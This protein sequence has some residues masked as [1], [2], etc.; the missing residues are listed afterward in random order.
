M[1]VYQRAG[2]FNHHP[3]R[4]PAPWIHPGLCQSSWNPGRR[5]RRCKHSGD[6]AAFFLGGFSRGWRE[7]KSNF[8]VM[9]YLN[10]ATFEVKGREKLLLLLLLLKITPRA[11]CVCLVYVPNFEGFFSCDSEKVRSIS[12]RAPSHPVYIP[13]SLSLIVFFFDAPKESSACVCHKTSNSH[14]GLNKN[15]EIGGGLHGWDPMAKFQFE[16]S[17]AN[18]LNSSPSF[19]DPQDY[20]NIFGKGS[21]LTF[22][23]CVGEHPKDS[24]SIFTSTILHLEHDPVCN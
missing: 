13:V 9:I 7:E 4:Q 5:P 11:I 24:Q 3:E 21:L 20:L 22:T 17:N 12:L 23:C 16:A 10:E 1:L 14:R 15:G 18:I 8:L 6:S 19:S 2:W